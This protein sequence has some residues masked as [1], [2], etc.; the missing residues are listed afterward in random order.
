MSPIETATG[1]YLY[2]LTPEGGRLSLCDLR[3]VGGGPLRGIA[4]R[5][6]QAV[7]EEVPLDEFGQE[8]LEHHLQDIRWVE[9]K[10]RTH[11]R[12]ERAIAA[13]TT[14]LP[15]RFCTILSDGADLERLM[16]TRK[17]H[18]RE[19][20]DRVA[21]ATEWGVKFIH[22]PNARPQASAGGENGAGK[23]AAYLLRKKQELQNREGEQRKA[24]A[25][26]EGLASDLSRFARER[27][28]IPARREQARH[29]V[30]NTALLVDRKRESTFRARVETLRKQ[31]AA[32]GLAVE[33]TGPWP[34]YSFAS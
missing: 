5:P 19:L 17:A 13:Q 22:Q 34:P 9:E 2:A 15:F 28:T 11:D 29:L 4:C 3:G 12:V 21:N 14:V 8:A 25:A 24:I 26:A 31:A 23:G 16:E 27:T 33:L 7:V 18:F 30:L 32:S 1:C 6:F 10:V 20:L